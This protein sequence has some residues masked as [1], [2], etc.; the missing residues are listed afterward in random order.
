MTQN[1][2]NKRIEIIHIGDELLLGIRENTH[3]SYLGKQFSKYGVQ[4]NAAHVIADT[5]EE[6]SECFNDAW[7]RADLVITTGGLGPTADDL[8]KEAI[9]ECL[10]LELEFNSDTKSKIESR[11]KSIGITEVP[12]NNLSQCY[13]PKG[14]ESIENTN[15][16]APG[17]WLEKDQKILIMLP[18]PPKE[19]VPMMENTVFRRLSSMGILS[20]GQSYRQ[21]RM[22]GIGES[23][24]E[25]ELKSL[26]EKHE[27]LQLALCVH[28]GVVD[29]RFSEKE[30]GVTPMVEAAIAE[31]EE[32][33]GEDVIGYGDCSLSKLIVK[34][35]I[36]NNLT[37]SVAESCTGGLITASL[38]DIPGA[39][40]A[41]KGG[42]VA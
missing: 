23:K 18:G 15:G 4:L 17:I 42:W 39:S 8:T 34:R 31:A 40:K 41:I 20:D 19:L 27:S 6:I 38:T 22:C 10:G 26:L 11:F 35:L 33:L 28:S 13:Q 3:L 16:T 5:S 12:E 32:I 36:E 1:K 14:S 7:S 24:V 21:L 37:L 29:V 25:T 30:K 2:T 9:A